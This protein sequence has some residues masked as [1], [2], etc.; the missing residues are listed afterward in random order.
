[1]I[2]KKVVMS[3]GKHIITT[4]FIEVANKALFTY[5]IPLLYDCV[6]LSKSL[7]PKQFFR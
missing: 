4:F 2:N 3:F 5:V 6:T 7:L 1:M